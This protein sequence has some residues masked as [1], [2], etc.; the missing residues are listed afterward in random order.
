MYLPPPALIKCSTLASESHL[1]R[2]AWPLPAQLD[3]CAGSSQHSCWW[4]PVPFLV[5]RSAPSRPPQSEPLAERQVPW[6]QP[7]GGSR[8]SAASSPPARPWRVARGPG[9]QAGGVRTL[10]NEKSGGRRQVISFPET[11]CRVCRDDFADFTASSKMHPWHLGRGGVTAGDTPA[12]PAG[13]QTH[14]HMVEL[15]EGSSGASPSTCSP[16]T[17]QA[18]CIPALL[19]PRAAPHARWAGLTPPPRSPP[20][21]HHGG[22]STG[23]AHPAPSAPRRLGGLWA[24][25]DLR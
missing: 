16:T 22:M 8:P 14:S 7:R 17:P 18:P 11:G 13:S 10:P 21:L 12:R 24:Q 20:P 9:W 19:A 25:G 23:R 5:G 15:G 6:P 3:T 4:S 2:G 1:T